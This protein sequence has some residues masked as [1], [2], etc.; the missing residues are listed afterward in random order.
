MVVVLVRRLEHL[1]LFLRSDLV[2]GLPLELV[3]LARRRPDMG[4]GVF[5]EWSGLV[6]IEF[7]SV[8][9][10]WWWCGV[11]WVYLSGI[12][13]SITTILR[14]GEWMAMRSHIF[15]VKNISEG[16]Y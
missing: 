8:F 10:V 13:D 14:G 5:G 15:I 7:Q 1:F 4:V 2:V 9:G 11:V 3:S 6:A 12:D 16:I